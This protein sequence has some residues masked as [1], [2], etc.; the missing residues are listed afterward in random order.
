MYL[1]G[2]QIT[3]KLELFDCEVLHFLDAMHFE[4]PRLMTDKL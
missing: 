4:V 1:L 2:F 3:R